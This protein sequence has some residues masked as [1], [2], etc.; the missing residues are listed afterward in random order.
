MTAPE[1]DE[2][3]IADLSLITAS[4]QQT[5]IDDSKQQG[6]ESPNIYLD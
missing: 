2:A 1:L 3:A 5:A 4:I 6:R